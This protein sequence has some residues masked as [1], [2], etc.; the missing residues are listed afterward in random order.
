MLKKE[1]FGKIG[2][3]IPENLIDFL[4][5]LTDKKIKNFCNIKE[6]PKELEETQIQMCIDLYD[7][8]YKNINSNGTTTENNS[9]NQKDIKS[10][11]RGD[12][13]IEFSLESEKLE[14]EKQLLK[15]LINS[16]NFLFNYEN[17]LYDFRRFRWE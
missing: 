4:I 8:R 7:L 1:D 6:V 9:S 5:S 17:E 2:S 13:Q 14:N 11:K 12:T 3:L 15:E 10:I 16:D